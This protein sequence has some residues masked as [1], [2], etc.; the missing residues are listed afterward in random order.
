MMESR[1]KIIKQAGVFASK[2]QLAKVCLS[3]GYF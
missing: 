2:S 1:Q 3:A